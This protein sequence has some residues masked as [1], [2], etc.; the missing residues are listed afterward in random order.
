[1]ADYYAPRW[2]FYLEEMIQYYFYGVNDRNRKSH[3]KE[4]T[5]VRKKI[6]ATIEKPFTRRNNLYPTIGKGKYAGF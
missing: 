1:M 6:F 5:F 4:Q 2:K 3:K